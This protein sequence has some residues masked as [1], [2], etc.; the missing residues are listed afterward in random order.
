[1]SIDKLSSTRGC[2]MIVCEVW[3]TFA[4]KLEDRITESFTLMIQYTRE[5]V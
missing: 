2:N 5:I 4:L 3:F 1:M